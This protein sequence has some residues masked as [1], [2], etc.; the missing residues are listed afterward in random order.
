LTLFYSREL[1]A[2]SKE[3]SLESWLRLADERKFY[4]YQADGY[5][6]NYPMQCPNAF[7]RSLYV[8]MQQVMLAMD[9]KIVMESYRGMFD[10]FTR[11]IR[12][13]LSKYRLADSL[14]V[15]ITG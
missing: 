14:F 2:L 1:E 9:G 8:N 4:Y 12:K 10:F 13:C 7:H 11:S 6:E 15:S 5:M 3:N